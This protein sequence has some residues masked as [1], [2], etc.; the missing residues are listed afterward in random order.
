[1]RQG[2]QAICPTLGHRDPESG[3]SADANDSSSSDD[4]GTKFACPHIMLRCSAF[5]CVAVLTAQGSLAP[6]LAR[7]NDA[8][9]WRVIDADASV[10][11]SVVRLKPHGD[12]AV[13]SHIGLALVQNLK[14]S[15]GTLEVDLR[16]AGNQTASFLGLAFGVADARTF[17]AV[18][19][20]PFRFADKDPDARRHA[21]QYVSWPEYTWEKLR[22]DKPGAFEA[23]I[24]PVPDPAGWFHV[25]IDVTKQKVSVSIDGSAQPCLM[26]D[27][28]GHREGDVGLLVDSM[29]GDFRNFRIRPAR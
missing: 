3:H 8:K 19:F 16:G 6:D 24:Q 17:D 21:V 29:P 15:E 26:V 20:R 1:M 28:L 4:P 5:F 18:Y 27:R 9:S 13:G 2:S 23:A 11:G 12:P 10:E 14:F 25:R 7:V 22:K